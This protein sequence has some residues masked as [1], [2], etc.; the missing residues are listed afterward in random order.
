M[1]VVPFAITELGHKCLEPG[2]TLKYEPLNSCITVLSIWII[3]IFKC[4]ASKHLWP[5]Q[6]MTKS[7]RNKMLVSKCPC[8]TFSAAMSCLE[9]HWF[10]HINSKYIQPYWP[11]QHASE[12]AKPKRNIALDH[13]HVSYFFKIAQQWF[14]SLCPNICIQILPTELHTFP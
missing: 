13:W 11:L 2:A 1:Y 8:L 5:L 7:W 14:N 12:Q 6:K 3:K 9:S 4:Y 10:L